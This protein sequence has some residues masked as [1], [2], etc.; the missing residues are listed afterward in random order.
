[1]STSD[2]AQLHVIVGIKGKVWSPIHVSSRFVRL[3]GVEGEDIKDAIHIKGEREQPLLVR[4]LQNSI[5]DKIDLE[6]SKGQD[7]NYQ[8]VIKNKIKKEASYLGKIKL[9]TNY[10]DKPDMLLHVVGHVRSKISVKPRVLIFNSLSEEQMH[11]LKGVKN[12]T[13][14]LFVFLE[15]GEDLSIEKVEVQR[16]L[17]KVCIHEREKGK[18]FELLIEPILEKLKKGLNTDYLKIFIQTEKRRVVLVPIQMNVT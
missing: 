14:S 10:L 1:M 12:Y 8:L 18:R 17:F 6:L 15:K 3:K 13:R 2:P 4:I 5:P 16:S 9:G 7:N 11:S